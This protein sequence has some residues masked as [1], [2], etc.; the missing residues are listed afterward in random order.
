MD[1]TTALLTAARRF[2][3]RSVT[4]EDPLRC[5]LPTEELPCTQSGSRTRMELL[6]ERFHVELLRS[7]EARPTNDDPT[8]D[9]I[10]ETLAMLAERTK[11]E[12]KDEFALA[13]VGRV[14][15]QFVAYIRGLSAEDLR[16]VAPL[17]FR[18]VLRDD[19]SDAIWARLGD[20]WLIGSAFWYPLSISARDLPGRIVA[21]WFDDFVAGYGA[22]RLRDVLAAHGID[23]VWELR[24]PLSYPIV[25]YEMDLCLMHPRCRMSEFYWTSSAMDWVVYTSHEQTIA[26]A[27]ECLVE[28]VLGSWPGWQELWHSPHWESGAPQGG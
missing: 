17:P 24:Y 9:Q 26:F 27:G 2:L 20:R 18:R 16:Q 8:T 22:A 12:G 23:R 6:T 15:E 14:R 7:I 5:S 19:G 21:F 25:E 1:E 10:L 11:P 3:L 13:V 28:A 4:Q